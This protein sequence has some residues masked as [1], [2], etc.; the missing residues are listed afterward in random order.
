VVRSL[1]ILKALTYA[2]TGGILAAATTSLPETP[3][4]MRNWDYRYCWLR[5]ATFSLYALMVGGY[6]E[7]ARA[8]RE[9]LLRAVAGKP[10]QLRIMYGLAGERRL[11]ELEIDWLPGYGGARPVRVGNAAHRQFQ[12]DVFGEVMDAFHFARRSG[13]EP[14][15]QAWEVQK[16]LMDF[17]ESAWEQADEGIWEVRGP[18][19]HFTHSKVMAWVAFDR[20]VKAIERSDLE[21][22]ADRWRNL[23]DAVHRDACRQGFDHELHS[24]VQYYGAKE[25]DASL[26]MIPLV[27]FLPASDPRM[28]GTVKAIQERLASNGFVARYRETA[29]VDGL[30]GREGAF[31]GCTLW[32]A[33]NLALQGR[34][35]E[36]Q[37]VFQRVL[38]V[39]NDVGLLSEE[40]DPVRR[41]LL[42]NFPQ[43]L[44]HVGLINTARN[45]QRPGGPA[46]HR[47][48]Q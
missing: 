18:S 19:R 28:V 16:V 11:T 31:L 4:G 30:T 44:S 2:P 37:E 48:S 45:L 10:S 36:A 33:D 17:L 6:L 7:E 21:G 9:W 12:L 15:A 29:D 42:G 35:T 41:R 39:R 1:I 40:Y 43:A 8:W 3:G 20:A 26:L 14:E 47:S 38:A 25:L 13:L 22:P 23:R 34:R 5:D 27:G 32:L 46:E 24:F